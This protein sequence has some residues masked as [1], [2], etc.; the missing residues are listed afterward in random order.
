MGAIEIQT[1][2][3]DE[4]NFYNKTNPLYSYYIWYFKHTFRLEIDL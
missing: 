1:T 2:V 3:L 4:T